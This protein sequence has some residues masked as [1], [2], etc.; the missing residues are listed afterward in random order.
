ME[1]EVY[2]IQT[3][4]NYI[5][6]LRGWMTRFHGV[7]S[8]YQKNYL[9]W[10]RVKEQR[11]DDA[12]SW[13]FGRVKVFTNTQR[14]K[15]PHCRMVVSARPIYLNLQMYHYL[16]LIIP[17]CFI[18]VNEYFSFESQTIPKDSNDLDI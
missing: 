18:T 2:H 15:L 5:S 8:D 9:A 17:S 13:L 16:L 3:L 1:D 12:K 11:R 14:G 4:N 7:G 6:R 10:F